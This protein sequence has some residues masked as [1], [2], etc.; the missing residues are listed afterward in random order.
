MQDPARLDRLLLGGFYSVDATGL[1]WA[2]RHPSVPPG[3][4]PILEQDDL[5]LWVELESVYNLGG[6]VFASIPGSNVVELWAWDIAGLVDLLGEALERDL[7]DDRRGQLHPGAVR[8][9]AAERMDR[10]GLRLADRRVQLSASSSV[11]DGWRDERRIE[12]VAAFEERRASVGGSASAT[13]T[14]VWRDELSG[15]PIPGTV[16]TITD[17]S[18]RLQVYVPTWVAPKGVDAHGDDVEVDVAAVETNGVGLDA[19]S[20]HLDIQRLV[21]AGIIDVPN[22][23]IQRLVEQMAD[24]DTSVVVTAIRTR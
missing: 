18:G 12:T 21:A 9:L 23:L 8:R 22:E 2:Q 16:G 20:A 15:G 4:L 13:L 14:G 6:R 10:D 3:L 5:E 24:L 11:P 1:A 7:V 19:L 17:G